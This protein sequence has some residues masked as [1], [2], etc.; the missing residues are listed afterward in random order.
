ML[1]INKI[2]DKPYHFTLERLA[3]NDVNVPDAII[4]DDLNLH[5]TPEEMLHLRR[6]Y[7]TRGRNVDFEVLEKYDPIGFEEDCDVLLQYLY[8]STSRI[9]Q[10]YVAAN[11]LSNLSDFAYKL[12]REL[13]YSLDDYWIIPPDE[14]I[15]DVLDDNFTDWVGIMNELDLNDALFEATVDLLDDDKSLN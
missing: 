11:P 4:P 10:D 2:H 12:S 9:M 13:P 1:D 7:K 3:P 8:M 6:F 15:D 14:L 5:F